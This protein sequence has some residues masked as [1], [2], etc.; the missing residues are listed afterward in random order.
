MASPPDDHYALVGKRLGFRLGYIPA[1]LRFIRETHVIFR[2]DDG[3]VKVR[4]N[5]VTIHDVINDTPNTCGLS[6]DAATPPHPGQRLTVRINSN[7]P[8]TLFAGP[9]QTVSLTYE[10]QPHQTVYPCQAI[11][12]TPLANRKLP[13]GSFVDTS[14][15]V[16]A[17]RSTS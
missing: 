5:S 11:D 3:L 9:L 17:L 2:L 13:Y 7:K 8:R 6:I 15:T 12:D 10:L 16:V 4:Y 1:H 14:A